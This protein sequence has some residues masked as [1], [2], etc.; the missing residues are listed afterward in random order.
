MK[1]KR[2][3]ALV[4]AA[5]L[6]VTGFSV[7]GIGVVQ[8]EEAHTEMSGE[9]EQQEINLAADRGSTARASKFLAASGNLPAREPGLAFDGISDNNG[10]AD[11][12][13]WQSGED[14]EFSEQWLEV[15]LGGI[16]VVS[17]IKVDFF[18][19]LYGD[20]RV[21]VSDSNAE[22]AVWTTIATAD[23]PEGTDL[24]LKKTVDVKENGKAREIP[25]YI[26]LYFTSG[27]S[28]AAN[29]SI[30]V[31]EFQVIGTKK[32]ESGY[33]T[34]TGNIALNKTASA[35][36]VEAAMPNLT[37]NLAVDGQK[38]D[39]S[40]WSAPTM[41]NG[42]SPNQQQT[43]QWLEID[44]RNEVTNIT[45]IDLYFYKL[46]YSIDYE[47]QTRADKKS[48]WKTVKH[49]TCQPG[50]EQN[51]HDSITDVEGKR[52]D[53]YVRFYFNKVNTNAGGNSVSV[54]EIEIH[55]DQVQT[56]E[57]TDPAPKNAKE[58]MDSV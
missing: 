29:R 36:G 50:N 49:V 56:P 22:D 54:Q 26:R 30:G 11:N 53:R 27:N 31:R 34:I 48:E 5:I 10:E 3:A 47:I 9:A 42:T 21:E 23:M 28:Q 37:A 24:N 33:E 14:A 35:S 32:S 58:A 13:R 45:S 17:E 51:K 2:V 40:R 12:S 18:A 57:V 20:F 4:M 44:L 19:R 8:A 16:C 46:V 43:P 1:K 39:T 7:P 55:G 25:R 41:K 15:D 52:L 38:S 6:G